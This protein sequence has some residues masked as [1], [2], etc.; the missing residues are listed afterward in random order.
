VGH[1]YQG[2]DHF[3]LKGVT[4]DAISH[5]DFHANPLSAEHL[6]NG[7]TRFN[8]FHFDGIIHGSNPSRVTTFRCVKAPKGPDVTILLDND[9]SG[10]TMKCKPGSTA[11]IN[12]AQIYNSMTDEERDIFENA[13]WEPAPYPFAWTGTRGLRTTGLGV[14]P[15]GQ[16]LPLDQLPAWSPDHVHMYPCVWLNPVTKE[17]V[18]QVFP[19]T[20]RRLHLNSPDGGKRVV[21]DLEEIR[22]RLNE[23]FDRVCMPEYIL[24][25]SCEEGDMLVWNNWVCLLAF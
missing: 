15:G 21:D 2:E 11:F 7:V 13:F 24:I 20:V 19:D 16:T 12:S 3:G 8:S 1:G 6:A 23:I 14:A 4:M 9:A 10:R 22:I 5:V 25:P 17:K 18:F